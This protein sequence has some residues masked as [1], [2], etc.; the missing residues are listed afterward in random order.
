MLMAIPAAA[1]A[2]L[3]AIPSMQGAGPAP[4]TR[5]AAM[6]PSPLV[7]RWLLDVSRIPAGERPRS[8]TIDFDEAAGKWTTKVK[9]VAPDGTVQRATSTA[10]PDGA[11]VPVEGNM[12]FIDSVS[13]RRPVP[14]T[15]I[16]TLGKGGAPVSTRVY[17]ATKDGRAM[18]ETIIWA[19]GGIPALE[20][21]YYKRAG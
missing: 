4:Q 8:V 3:L 19:S 14:G 1:S 13:L 10:A 5:A 6:T 21:T 16:M 11:G 15:L 9:I 20:T 2:L 17:T 18:T 12:A 7:G